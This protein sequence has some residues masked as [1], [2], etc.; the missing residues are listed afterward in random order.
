MR[1]AFIF[2]GYGREIRRAN[3][4]RYGRREMEPLSRGFEYCE[5]SGR[6]LINSICAGFKCAQY[7]AFAAGGLEISENTS[8]SVA[9]GE[10]VASQRCAATSY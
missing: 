2:K 5:W 8:S 1:L 6:K 3:V 7:R 4:C 9:S 10:T